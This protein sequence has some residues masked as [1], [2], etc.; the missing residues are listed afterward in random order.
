MQNM[1]QMAASSA[2]AAS[3]A[4]L[5]A[6]R[7]AS[8]ESGVDFTYLVNKAATESS[9]NPNAKASTSS[10]SGLY[11]FID[12][13]WLTELS[14]HGAQYGLGRQAAA[15][16]VDSSG[17]AS[18]SD[19]SMRAEIMNLKNDP[20]AAAEM[21]AAFTKDNQAYLQGAVGGSIGP[22]ELY[23]AHFLGA[24][25]AA[26]FLSA[27][28]RDPAQAAAS[29]M[30]QAADSNEPVFYHAD[31]TPR[32]LSEVYQRFA[33]HFNGGSTTATASYPLSGAFAALGSGGSNVAVQSIAGEDTA[34]D[35]AVPG[36]ASLYEMLVLSQLSETE[37]S[38]A[39]DAGVN[40]KQTGN[41]EQPVNE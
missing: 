37:I 14:Q 9:F 41:N 35:M 40:G 30:P 28:R 8:A 31:G 7:Q 34:S 1:G 10:A 16:S 32:S 33:A 36:R 17:H 24:G 22:T 15:I 12:Q 27:M 4:V 38:A 5:S 21:A 2:S 13:T 19:P 6:I 11:Q 25:G 29:V 3:P 20:A 18:V 26:K 23:L 39:R